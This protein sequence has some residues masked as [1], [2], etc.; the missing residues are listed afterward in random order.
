M[1][2]YLLYFLT[3]VAV[4]TFILFFR[5]YGDVPRTS[6]SIVAVV[7]AMALFGIAAWLTFFLERF[8]ALLALLCL[9]A[10][11]PWGVR[12]WL[13]LPAQTS[14]LIPYIM[15]A[16]AVVSALVLFALLTSARYAFSRRS[17][18]SGTA[19]PNLFL[20]LVLALIPLAVAAAW[21]VV[22]PRI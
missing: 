19:R 1:T 17:W 18:R 15:M 14:N 6:F 20:K 12:V 2:R 22:M 8:G 5:G 4:A 16:H 13:L 21:F 10:I 9:L 3:G 7:G 11:L